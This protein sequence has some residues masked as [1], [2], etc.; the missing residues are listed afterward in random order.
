MNNVSVTR[1]YPKRRQ[2]TPECKARWW[3]KA[4]VLAHLLHVLLWITTST[5]TYLGAGLLS[6]GKQFNSYR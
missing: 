5:P 4:K 3:L 6:Q 1:P 2:Y